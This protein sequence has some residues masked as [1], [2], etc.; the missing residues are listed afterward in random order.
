[1]LS[2]SG[3]GDVNGDGIDD[4]LIG[5][6]YSPSVGGTRAFAGRSYLIFGTSAWP[7][8]LDL[9]NSSAS[10]MVFDG[11]LSYAES[12]K[13]VSRAGDVNGDGF[14]DL[15]IGAPTA[16]SQNDALAASGRTY[17][18]YGGNFT[19]SVTRPGTTAADVLNGTTGPDVIIGGQGDD[20]LN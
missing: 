6:P 20:T 7:A 17:V 5:S 4:V 10:G 19:S 9:L 12:G 11:P 15:I 18:V 8:S 3:V 14:A 1:G 2:V 13:A 16:R